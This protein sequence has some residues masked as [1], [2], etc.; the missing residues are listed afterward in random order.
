MWRVSTSICLCLCL[1]ITFCLS[2]CLDMFV[3]VSQV[4]TRDYRASFGQFTQKR[5]Y[6]KCEN[7]VDRGSLL[8]WGRQSNCPRLTILLIPRV[9]FKIARIYEGFSRRNANPKSKNQSSSRAQETTYNRGFWGDFL[10]YPVNAKKRSPKSLLRYR[11]SFFI[12][13]ITLRLCE[14]NEFLSWV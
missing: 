4:W 14:K 8:T 12:I 7:H 13:Y 2:F 10:C 3:R 11:Y 9:P 6:T 1:S 5:V